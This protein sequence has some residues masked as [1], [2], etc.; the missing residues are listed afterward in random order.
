VKRE[1]LTGRQ[2]GRLTCLEFVGKTKHGISLWLCKCNCGTIKTI[3]SADL[4]SGRTQSC[5]CL[6]KKRAKEAHVTHNL[7]RDENGK[8]TKL[9]NVWGSMKSRCFCDRCHDYKYYGARGI[10]VCNEWLDYKNFYNWSIT[11]GYEQGLT[12]DRIDNFG[13]YEPANCRWATRSQQSNNTRVVR[14]VEYL[15]KSMSL[16]E[17]A[18][19]T[20]INRRT[21]HYRINQKKW[22]ILQA[23]AEQV[24]KDQI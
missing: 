19:V 11:N 17:L 1:D 24:R 20:G 15:G 6:Q 21:L 3:R 5:G 2:F 18:K 10:R 23:I 14:L 22:G 4:K 13:N 12:I 9:F 8:P 7:S 16:G